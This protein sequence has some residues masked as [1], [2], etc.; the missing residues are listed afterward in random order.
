MTTMSTRLRRTIGIGLAALT[1]AA[2]LATAAPA[3]AAKGGNGGGRYSYWCAETDPTTG[4]Q[5]FYP[6]GTRKAAMEIEA[7]DPDVS[8]YRAI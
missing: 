2:S 7:A 5:Y 8:C 6:V 3:D 1:L 4:I